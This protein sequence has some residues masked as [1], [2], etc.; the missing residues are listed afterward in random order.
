MPRREAGLHLLLVLAEPT[1]EDGIV[2]GRDLVDGRWRPFAELGHNVWP[3]CL[4]WNSEFRNDLDGIAKLSACICPRQARQRSCLIIKKQSGRHPVYTTVLS[5]LVLQGGSDGV[6]CAASNLPLIIDGG[7]QRAE[8]DF[9]R[10]LGL[11]FRRA[12]VHVIPDVGEVWTPSI[13][14]DSSRL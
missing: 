9:L 8:I 5:A 13:P 6:T 4:I 12:N 7:T 10:N 14:R 3:I 11:D 2:V 1:I